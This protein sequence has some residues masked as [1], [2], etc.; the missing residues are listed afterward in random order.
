MRA[1]SNVCRLIFPSCLPRSKLKAALGKRATEKGLRFGNRLP[2]I[3]RR[4]RKRIPKNQTHL[5]NSSAFE[6]MEFASREEANEL[7]HMSKTEHPRATLSYFKAL[8]AEGKQWKPNIWERVL[9]VLVEGL[10]DGNHEFISDIEG[11][12]ERTNKLPIKSKLSCQHLIVRAHLE[13]NN[14]EAAKAL[15]SHIE[16]PVGVAE[17]MWNSHLVRIGKDLATYYNRLGTKSSVR[18]AMNLINEGKFSTAGTLTMLVPLISSRMDEA[19]T[20]EALKLLKSLRCPLPYEAAVA[21]CEN[22]NGEKAH[23]PVKGTP[24]EGTPTARSAYLLEN[25]TNETIIR[26]WVS[27]FKFRNDDA[28]TVDELKLLLRRSLK[29]AGIYRRPSKLTA[30]KY[31]KWRDL[32]GIEQRMAAKDRIL[33]EGRECSWPLKVAGL[34]SPLRQKLRENI[35]RY[36]WENHPNMGGLLKKLEDHVVSQEISIAIDAPNVAFFGQHSKRISYNHSKVNIMIRELIKGGER[37]LLIQPMSKMNK[38]INFES[39]DVQEWFDENMLFTVPRGYDDL[40]WMYASLIKEGV[41]VISNDKMRNHQ[42]LFSPSGGWDNYDQMRDLMS[43]YTQQIRFI[44]YERNNEDNVV[45]KPSPWILRETQVFELSGGKG[46]EW[47]IPII[48]TNFKTD[49]SLRDIH[50]NAESENL[51]L[52][53]LVNY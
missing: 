16:K 23:I 42:A 19:V 8:E 35:E 44:F 2:M 14:L 48:E 46:K 41:R 37:P 1:L 51:W 50:T 34:S 17:D 32:S 12:Y 31:L 43:W 6:G 21:I 33:V 10:A 24:K 53:L 5:S 36:I 7:I 15:I 3:K 40:F 22:W 25:V 9:F 26:E 20:L 13:M 29:D 11:I 18:Q 52:R 38:R 47:H 30:M 28:T 39:K 49:Y 45:F 4:Y 27:D